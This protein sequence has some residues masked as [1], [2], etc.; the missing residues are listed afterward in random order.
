MRLDMAKHFLNEMNVIQTV[1]VS[2]QQNSDI[3]FLFYE[4]E[5]EK[6]NIFPYS[7]L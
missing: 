2:K 4:S 6:E 1:I 7:T 5:M 3:H